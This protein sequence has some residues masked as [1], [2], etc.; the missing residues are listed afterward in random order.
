LLSLVLLRRTRLLGRDLLDRLS[1]LFGLLVSGE[2]V[3]DGAAPH[4]VGV[5]LVQR[6]RVALH[7]HAK[8]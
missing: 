7:W 5:R 8:S 1:R 4:H 2:A 3:A 6:R